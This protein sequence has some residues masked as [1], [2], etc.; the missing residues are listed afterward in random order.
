M[1]VLFPYN[2]G[3]TSLSILFICSCAVYVYAIFTYKDIKKNSMKLLIAGG[4]SVGFIT[5]EYFMREGHDVTI[6]EQN[7]VQIKDIHNK[8]DVTAIHG[9]ATDASCF[10]EANAHEMDLFLALTDDDE[11]NIISCTLAKYAGVPYR[12]ARLS[13]KFHLAK[14][15]VTALKDL[16]I[17]EIIDTEESIIHEIGKL[18]EYPG[19]A[20]IKH[21]MNGDYVVA[22]FSFSRDS[23]HY[24]KTLSEV[25]FSFPVV[26]I[27]Y[28]KVGPFQAYNEDVVI[29]EFLY[30]YYA[31]ETKHL[32]ELHKTLLP[33]SKEIKR[34]MI[35]GTGYKSDSTSCRLGEYLQKQGVE[36]ITQV[37][38]N[39]E[40]AER[41][42]KKCQFP[43][44]V[45]DPSKPHFSKTEDLHN[46]DMF[47]ALSNQFEKNLFSCSLA[48]Q[49]HV[50]YTISLVRYPEHVNFVSTIPLTEFLNP[51]MV[52]ANKVMKH[53]KV[54]TIVSRTIL[55]YQQLETIEFIISEKTRLANKRIGELDF[56]E[57]KI[58]ALRR[59]KLF[60]QVDDDTELHI[61]DQVLLA[62]LEKEK[63][64]LREI[65]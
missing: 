40:L 39:E 21:F 32:S 8:L 20:D 38:E 59:G 6:I 60:I 24:G 37:I 54:D 41:I 36:K 25:T 10:D 15:N 29:N 34:V 49:E 33:E 50:P 53:H 7:D 44:I 56:K 18:I 3:S 57:S 14:E 43:V 5:A 17:D 51:A 19:A 63:N 31:C 11:A 23:Q 22:A 55:N 58:L 47:I 46:Q 28:T 35:F 12:I 16:G 52:T 62:V 4:G 64:I 27:G 30:V 9:R 45:G 26:A 61:G 65:I 13:E 48:Y 2:K 1:D 42:S